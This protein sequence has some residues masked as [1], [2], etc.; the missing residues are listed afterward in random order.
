MRN[1]NLTIDAA[2]VPEA[3]PEFSGWIDIVFYYK[4]KA[5]KT[6]EWIVRAKVFGTY[7]KDVM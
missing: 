4:I 6:I 2:I 5:K 7:T 3:F 1:F